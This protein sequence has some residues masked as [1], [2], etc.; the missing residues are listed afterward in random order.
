[1]TQQ[2]NGETGIIGKAVEKAF[3]LPIIVGAHIAFKLVM[4]DLSVLGFFVRFPLKAIIVVISIFGHE[5]YKE[6]VPK[7]QR[8][9]IQQRYEEYQREYYEKKKQRQRQR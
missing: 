5:I 4:L 7:H 8:K 1:M 6:V 2:D 9:L 3:M